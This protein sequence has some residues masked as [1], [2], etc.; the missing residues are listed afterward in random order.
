[1]G[2]PVRGEMTAGETER[3]SLLFGAI[4]VLVIC[5]GLLINEYFI[6]F[7]FSTDGI[8][9]AATKWQVRGLMA[10]LVAA[11]I[12]LFLF[13]D[14]L[15][16]AAQ[17][18]V[19]RHP[20]TTTLVLGL[21]VSAGA[22]IG[23]ETVYH[24]L[25]TIRARKSGWV[26][27]APVLL[28]GT[29]TKASLTVRGE[30]VYDVTYNIDNRYARKTSSSAR[31]ASAQ[32]DLYF[33]GG[34]F[35][36][37]EGV[38]DDETL[39]SIV[40]RAAPD[41]RVTNFGFPGHGPA[42]MLQRLESDAALQDHAGTDAMLVYV[43]IPGHV[44]RVAGSMRVAT[45]WGRDFPSYAINEDDELFRM[46]TFSDS[47]PLVSKAYAFLSRERVLAYYNV[48]LPLRIGPKHLGLT[49]RVIAESRE[50]F[51]ARFGSDEF[52]V[53]LYPSHPR[54]E[55]PAKE[56]IPYL[57]AIDLS[58]FD[59]TDLFDSDEAYW[60]PHDEHPTPLAHEMA[61]ERLVRDLGLK[62]F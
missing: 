7:A 50:R 25:G 59:Y 57:D 62:A 55:F 1:M 45:S 28:P 21:A 32:K 6:A 42:Q 58:Y 40:A 16:K 22:F 15:E 34:S 31:A 26:I 13:R 29:T 14:R 24:S 39:P 11:G 23:I 18:I 54:D 52:Y 30:T 5:C 12:L 60:L 35:V 10:G 20:N 4:A 53:V 36:F 19:R 46:G 51:L 61:G 3:K 56:I 33:F 2:Y 44:R 27:Q 9:S 47:H 41:W 8:L 43:F 48:D 37:G 17:A 49:A 38:E